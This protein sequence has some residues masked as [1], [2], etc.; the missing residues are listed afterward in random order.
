MVLH[1]WR[2]AHD[3]LEVGFASLGRTTCEARPLLDPGAGL[4]GAIGRLGDRRGARTCTQAARYQATATEVGLDLDARVGTVDSGAHDRAGTPRRAPPSRPLDASRRAGGAARGAIAIMGRARALP[5]GRFTGDPMGEA[6]LAKLVAENCGAA[7][8]I[9]D[10]F[11]GV[12]PP[13]RASPSA[14]GPRRTTTRS[15]SPP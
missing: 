3:V 5:P 14:P 10:L 4:N 1:A 2:G 6:V 12:G 11:A 13:A 8:R 7:R 15:R 9:A